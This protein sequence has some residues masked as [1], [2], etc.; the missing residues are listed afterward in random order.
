MRLLRLLPAA[1]TL[2]L[3]ACDAG[4]AAPGSAAPPVI[5]ALPRALTAG[6]Q[7]LVTASATF[8]PALL[9]KV[10]ATRTGENV[11]ISPLSASMALGMTLNGAEGRTY[12]EMRTALGFGVLSRTEINEGYRDLISLLRALDPKVDFR[13]ANA[14]WFSQLFAPQVAPSF[15]SDAR[16]YFDATSAG[17]DFGAPSA[18]TTINGWVKTSTNDRIPTIVQSLSPDLVM[19]LVNAIYFKGDWRTAFDR[20]KTSAAPFTTESGA[21]VSVPMM[22]RT[23]PARVGTHDGRTVVEMGYGGDAFVMSII[24]PRPGESVN[25]LVAALTGNTWAAAMSSLG[26]AEVE[27]FLPRF[28]LSWEATLND[29]L[30]ALGMQRAFVPREADFS[31]LSPSAGRQ[32]YVSFVKQKTFVDVH[33]L[34]T[35]AAAVTAVGVGIVSVPQRATVRVDR[36]F[37]FAIRERLSGTILFMGKIVQPPTTS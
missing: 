20:S 25:A 2:L 27:L 14:I 26:G 31:R 29:P 5:S 30:R 13:I 7:S 35:E 23:A 33:E 36:P 3:A 24:L 21:T 16:Q 32:L 1:A 6:E 17:L 4:P 22:R 12:D 28:S 8:A 11:F 19:L 37:V 34:G 9:A 10:N 15:L 18:V